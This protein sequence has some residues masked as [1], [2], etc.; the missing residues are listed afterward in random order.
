MG[1]AARAGL[2]NVD[3]WKGKVVC[4]YVM[5][6]FWAVGDVLDGVLFLS[7]RNLLVSKGVK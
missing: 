6:F 1:N 7:R 2:C 3:K 4:I 5:R